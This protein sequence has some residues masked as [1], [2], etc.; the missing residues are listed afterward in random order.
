MKK[1]HPK[2]NTVIDD[3]NLLGQLSPNFAFMHCD[4]TNSIKEFYKGN[5]FSKSKRHRSND[6]INFSCYKVSS[7]IN[8][9]IFFEQNERK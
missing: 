6:Y 4:E 8:F 2:F 3:P 9:S 7:T 1:R 5:R